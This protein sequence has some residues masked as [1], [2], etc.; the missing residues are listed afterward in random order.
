MNNAGWQD[1]LPQTIPGFL[2]NQV[3]QNY[4]CGAILA[5]DRPP[6]TYASLLET[7]RAEGA[8]LSSLGIR[9]AD[10]IGIVLPNGPEM[11]VAFLAT[12]SHAVAAPLNPDYGANEFAFYLTD[13][14]ARALIVPSGSQSPAIGVANARGIPIVELQTEADAPAGRFSLSLGTSSGETVRESITPEDIAL[15]LHTSGTT[16][17]PKMVP[18]THRNLCLSAQGI[19]R[20][21][22]LTPVDC[23]LNIMPLFHIHGLIAAVLSSLMAGASVVCTPGLDVTRWFRWLDEFRPTWYTAVPTMHQAILGRA[24]HHEAVV[25]NNRLRF[26]RSCSS[27]LSPTLM[28]KLEVAFGV[29]VLESYGMT[30]ASH[31]IAGNPL[32]PFKHKAGSVGLAAGPEVAI[33]DEEGNLLP[34]GQTGEIVLRGPTITRGYEANPEA[35]RTAFVKGWFRTGDQGHIDDEGYTYISARIKEIINRGGEKISP[36]EIEEVLLQHPEVSQAVAYSLPHVQLGEDVGAAVVLKAGAMADE[37]ALRRFAAGQLAYFKVPRVIRVLQEIPKGATGKIQRIGMAERLGLRPIDDSAIQKTEFRAPSTPMQ[38]RLARIWSEVLA[39]K[40]IGVDDTFFAMGGNSLLATTLMVR[41]TRELGAQL[42]LV[43]FMESPTIAGIERRIEGEM[44][45]RMQDNSSQMIVAVQPQGNL[46]PLFCYPGR[47]GSLIGFWNLARCLGL[48]QPVFAF[49][50]NNAGSPAPAISV[51][52]IASDCVR[53]LRERRNQGP[54][55]LLGNCFGGFVTLEMARQLLSDGEKVSMLVM[56]DCFNH[57]WRRNLPF[58]PL[59]AH[60]TKHAL[61]RSRFHVK[62]LISLNTEQRAAYLRERIERF[63]NEWRIGFLQYVYDWSAYRNKPIPRIASHIRH[64]NRWAERHYRRQAYSG[65]VT[66]FKTLDPAGG[67]FPA[68]LMGWE[69]LLQGKVVSH[70]LPG[71][72]LQMLSEPT[73]GRVAQVLREHMRTKYLS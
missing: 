71:A 38:H 3:A 13:L 60:K 24:G 62:N 15:V 4:D 31:Q 20:W 7:I 36:R 11:A 41:V 26:I 66:L 18:L 59:L 65:E 63:G 39:M 70:S 23:C 43:D 17:R 30:E 51:E 12:A 32:P 54:Y 35:N 46:P 61:T 28:E 49:T 8:K 34:P 47:D 67:I 73:V 42:S 16:S 29:P 6:L 27:A 37:P 53:L 33:M 19:A 45:G 52:K 1:G 50:A 72:H 57:D 58:A 48:E 69:G 2:N 56:L 10:R 5:P 21:F 64:A 55:F 68:P 25:K 22:S 14:N 44:A 40:N 9:K